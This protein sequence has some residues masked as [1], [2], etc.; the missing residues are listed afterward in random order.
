M[1]EADG[2]VGHGGRCEQRDEHEDKEAEH[3]ALA[4]TEVLCVPPVGGAGDRDCVNG[5]TGSP[6]DHP[7]ASV[8]RLR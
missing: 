6:P 5:R 8:T 1:L 4:G 2:G 3:A 7:L